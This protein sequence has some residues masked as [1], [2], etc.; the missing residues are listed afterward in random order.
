MTPGTGFSRTSDRFPSP[1]RDVL[2]DALFSFFVMIRSTR[3]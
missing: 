3:P 1:P 2:F